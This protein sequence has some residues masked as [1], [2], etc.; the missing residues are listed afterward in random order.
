M[1]FSE[2]VKEARAW[3]QRDG[4][5]TYRALKREF[6][7]DDEFLDDLREQLIDADR[8]AVEEDGRILVWV[9][10]RATPPQSARSQPQLQSPSTYTPP[11]TLSTRPRTSRRTG[12]SESIWFSD[13][14]SKSDSC[15]VGTIQ[16]SSGNRLAKGQMATNESVATTIRRPSEASLSR[17]PV[18]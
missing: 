9:G 1:K 6:E 14:A 18:L 4:R 12:A 16:T 7:L 10:D 3:L 5:L 13:I 17:S 15:D 8:V 11:I 2:I